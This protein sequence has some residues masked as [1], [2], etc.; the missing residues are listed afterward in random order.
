MKSKLLTL[1]V[2]LLGGDT[3][4]HQLLPAVVQAAE[5]L[6]HCHFCVYGP[7]IDTPRIRSVPTQE[8][9]TMDDDPLEA[10][11][12]KP[13]ASLSLA[14]KDLQAQHTDALVSIG[15]TGALV[16]GA[17]LHLEKLPGILRPALLALLPTRKGVLAVIDVGAN[18]TCRAV[19]LQQFAELGVAYMQKQYGIQHPRV[20]L[21][22]I[23]V[24]S[25]KGRA[26][27]R[28]AYQLLQASPLNFV[29]NIEGTVAFHGNVDVLVTDGFSGNVFLKASEGMA[30][31]IF[32]ES[33]LEQR[34][35]YEEY[36]GALLCGLSRTVIKCHGNSGP[37][38]LLHALLAAGINS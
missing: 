3:P 24:E 12:L 25:Q 36:P 13:N 33:H 11:R 38:A 2:D 19:H 30:S 35:N 5:R 15:N 28:E 21:L 14:L 1:G 18:V 26:E 32:E 17:I 20:G 34:F 10:V 7:T 27:M 16:T 37:N 4:P 23:G 31:F 6:P 29:G 22:N 8:F 9:I